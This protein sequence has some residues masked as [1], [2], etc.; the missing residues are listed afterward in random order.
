MD[1]G[2]RR[3]V[4]ERNADG[5]QQG[6][7]EATAVG[8]FDR[9][10]A[11]NNFGRLD[12]AIVELRRGLGE[13][14][15]DPD[16]LGYL[17]WLLFF[18]GQPEQAEEA[19]K[20]ALAVRPADDRALNTLCEVTIAAGRVDEGLAHARELQQHF[21]D[22]PV[23]HLNAAYALLADTTGSRAQKR[24][25]R[26]EARACLDRALEL[27]PEHVPTL[28][29]VT[30]MLRRLDEPETAWETLDR[31]LALDPSNDGLLLLA[32]EREAARVSGP[33][34]L[35]GLGLSAGH[36]AAA[37]R[38]MS[39]VLAENPDHRGA[40]REIS[41]QVWA[42]TQLLAGLALWMLVGLSTF[43]YLVFG[44]PMAGSQ[45]TRMRF[46][47]ALLMLPAAWFVLLFVIRV[48][49]LPKRF[50]RRLYAPVWWVWIGYAIAALGGLGVM[51]WALSL[52]LRSGETQ[53]AMQGSYVGGITM[54]IGFTA[55]LLLIAEL[56]FVF[57]RFRSEQRSG[58]YPRDEEG[59]AAARAEGRAGLWGTIR[60]GVAVLIVLMPLYAAPIAMRPEAAGGF[61]AVAAAFG[62][63]PLV[64]LL[65][66][67][68]RILALRRA[69]EGSETASSGSRSGRS[70]S[71]IIVLI[72]LIALILSAFGIVGTW[73]LADRHA[74]EFDPPATPWELESQERSEKLREM[75]ERS[76]EMREMLENVT[77]PEPFELDLGQ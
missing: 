39:G 36:E 53:L 55:W 33:Q 31:A 63:P 21:P 24:A 50:M 12:Q 74:A 54:G 17:G 42:R 41:D 69:V 38:L 2:E 75:N 5:E 35:Q 77:P 6:R 72:T 10:D 62:F 45:R 46:A 67:F 32:A 73:L 28:H 8:Y 15:E 68:G 20:S 1:D 64:T 44:E 43:A 30:V 16:L 19:A 27:A 3:T 66:R 51:L 48:K 70:G 71:G 76:E 23:S 56:L 49:G 7:G 26:T 13:F 40:A 11:L 59:L 22:W 29:R 47:E 18:A 14:P 4:G 58:L 37:L 9:A 34:H 65:L 52:G 25:R 60:V 61:A 57:A